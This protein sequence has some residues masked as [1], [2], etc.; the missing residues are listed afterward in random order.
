MPVRIH[1]FTGPYICLFRRNKKTYYVLQWHR[2]AMKWIRAMPDLPELTLHRSSITID[3]EVNINVA[4]SAG[5]TAT[6]THVTSDGFCLKSGEFYIPIVKADKSLPQAFMLTEYTPLETP[7]TMVD[8]R[9]WSV[10][11]STTA[12]TATTATV[13]ATVIIPPPLAIF[14]E[15]I[16]KR[17]AWLIAEDAS[18]NS[19][20]CPIST[21]IISPITASV[22]TCFHVFETE[23]INEWVQRHPINTP[24]P[25][26]RKPCEVTSAFDASSN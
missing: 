4:T 13:V 5:A 8:I 11:I 26:C 3:A 15:K 9:L 6:L 10:A 1:T 20:T 25:L 12:P 16:P 21:N 18:K 19:E 7:Y 22:T 17:I 2:T 14:Q 23:Y 24:C